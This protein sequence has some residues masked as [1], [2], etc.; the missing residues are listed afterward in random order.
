MYS[1]F[2]LPFMTVFSH[3]HSNYALFFTSPHISSPCIHPVSFIIFLYSSHFFIHS[4]TH[5][6]IHACIHSFFPLPSPPTSLFSPPSP[7]PKLFTPFLT[8]KH[9]KSVLI[10]SLSGCSCHSPLRQVEANRLLSSISSFP[11]QQNTT[12]RS[13]LVLSLHS[14]SQTQSK[15]DPLSISVPL[16][17]QAISRSTASAIAMYFNE[18]TYDM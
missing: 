1:M 6:F 10:P 18:E 9:F 15:Y 2:L 16:R 7:P 8:S 11:I 5:S 4:I 13:G 14:V 17:S 12:V 3:S